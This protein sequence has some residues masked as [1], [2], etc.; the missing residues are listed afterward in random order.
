VIIVVTVTVSAFKNVTPGFVKFAVL[1]QPL[2]ERGSLH[3][4]LL[5]LTRRNC[6]NRRKVLNAE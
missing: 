5:F 4:F 1:A 2:N 3:L 6:R